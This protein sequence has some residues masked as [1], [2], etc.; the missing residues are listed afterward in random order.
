MSNTEQVARQG[1]SVRS[2]RRRQRQQAR[3][4]GRWHVASSC[5][6]NTDSQTLTPLS[7]HTWLTGRRRVECDDE[8]KAKERSGRFGTGPC[9]TKCHESMLKPILSLFVT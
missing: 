7:T 3:Q 5:C 1:L 4:S 6:T 8:A 9:T 2:S